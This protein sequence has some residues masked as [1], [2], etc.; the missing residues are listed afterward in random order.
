MA[1]M[2]MKLG[3][4]HDLSLEFRRPAELA[5]DWD[6]LKRRREPV[7]ILTDQLDQLDAAIEAGADPE[8]VTLGN[9]HAPSAELSL[10]KTVECSSSQLGIL[11]RWLR[12][13]S[14]LEIRSGVHDLP[15][16]LETHPCLASN[17]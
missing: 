13:G 10:T 14:R 12:R 6:Q 4:P 5:H 9:V 1:Q 7:M 8:T 11:R 17:P 15:E 2:V 3:A 16:R